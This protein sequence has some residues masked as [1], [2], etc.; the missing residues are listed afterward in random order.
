MI[1]A[2]LQNN[3]LNPPRDHRHHSRHHYP[4]QRFIDANVFRTAIL[5][6]LQQKLTLIEQIN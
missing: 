6:T 3:L 4:F 2:T 5:P 1:S